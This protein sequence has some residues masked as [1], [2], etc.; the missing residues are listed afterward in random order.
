MDVLALV[1]IEGKD[2]AGLTIRKCD[3]LSMEEIIQ[4][5]HQKVSKIKTQQDPT[6][7]KQT[8]LAG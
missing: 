2:L 4:K 5:L 1:D 8:G 7:K 3:K 6:H